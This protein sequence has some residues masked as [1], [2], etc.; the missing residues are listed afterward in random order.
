VERCENDVKVI[1]VGRIIV[2]VTKCNISAAAGKIILW[3]FW[4]ALFVQTYRK[5]N[6]DIVVGRMITG[7]SDQIC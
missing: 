3:L 1:V 6:V 7:Y 4:T 5:D 2:E